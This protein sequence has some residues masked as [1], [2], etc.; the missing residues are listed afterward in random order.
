MSAMAC[1]NCYLP[2]W[3]IWLSPRSGQPICHWGTVIETLVLSKDSGTAQK[4]Q[5]IWSNRF[6]FETIINFIEEWNIRDLTKT[7]TSENL[8][9][10]YQKTVEPFPDFRSTTRSGRTSCCSGG[11]TGGSRSPTRSAS[12]GERSENLFLKFLWD[13]PWKNCCIWWILKQFML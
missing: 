3:K 11:R 12:R 9:K 10:I 4:D 5:M 8:L 6:F 1:S 2:A 13:A 7:K